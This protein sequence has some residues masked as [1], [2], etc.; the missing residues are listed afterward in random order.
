MGDMARAEYVLEMDNYAGAAVLV[1]IP[2]LL[3]IWNM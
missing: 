2:G 3:C 1:G